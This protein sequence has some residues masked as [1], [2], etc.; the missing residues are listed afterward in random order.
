[1][2]SDDLLH[3]TTVIKD[4]F[5]SNEQSIHA[6]L[7]KYSPNRFLGG[8]VR[9]LDI[10]AQK[11]SISKKGGHKQSLLLALKKLRVLNKKPLTIC[12]IQRQS[13]N[14]ELETLVQGRK[15]FEGIFAL[16]QRKALQNILASRLLNKTDYYQ[17]SNSGSTLDLIKARICSIDRKSEF[18]PE[19]Y[20]NP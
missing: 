13:R 7:A 10:I 2:H 20:A 16:Q 4:S 18:V 17:G 8:S 11:T 1:M 19:L 3:L 14:H 12:E 15:K 9:S 6:K 5:E